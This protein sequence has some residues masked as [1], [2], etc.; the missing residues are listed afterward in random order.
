MSDIYAPAWITTRI[1]IGP[2]PRGNEHRAQLAQGG[3]T[4]VIDC[5]TTSHEPEW[6]L[7]V[8]PPV[9]YWHTPTD[10]DGSDKREWLERWT[11]HA[12]RILD[13]HGR[14]ARMLIH[15]AA[16]INRSA[17]LAWCVCRAL[18]MPEGQIEQAT[19]KCRPNAVE[20]GLRYRDEAID[21]GVRLHKE[22]MSTT[23]DGYLLPTTD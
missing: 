15:C 19:R 8:R 2:A 12:L 5:T 16:G 14:N 4:H 11:R 18:G 20:H 17:S 1:A 21:V 13:A 9:E 7:I 6:K 10:D 3:I 22:R 23:F